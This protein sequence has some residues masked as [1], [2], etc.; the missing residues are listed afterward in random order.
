MLNDSRGEFRPDR[1]GEPRPIP[2]AVNVEAHAGFKAEEYPKA[3]SI[4]EKTF[5]VEKILDRWYGVDHAYFKIRTDDGGLY[6]LRYDQGTDSWE[7]V[8]MDALGETNDG[9]RHS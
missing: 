5:R 7:L 1:A 9:L 4:G 3:F 8:Y 2:V 6:I